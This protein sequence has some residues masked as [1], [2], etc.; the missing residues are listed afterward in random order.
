MKRHL[1]AFHRPQ[2]AGTHSASR[3]TGLPKELDWRGCAGTTYGTQAPHG[4]FRPAVS[5]QE[6]MVLGDWKSYRIVLRYAH[7]PPKRSATRK[8]QANS[9]LSG[10][11]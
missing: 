3:V 5:L 10:G 4:R 1:A 7:L 9:S 8:P 11:C 6:L 2:S